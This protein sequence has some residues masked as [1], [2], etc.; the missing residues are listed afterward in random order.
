MTTSAFAV[1]LLR[2]VAGAADRAAAGVID[3]TPGFLRVFVFLEV[4]NEH[5][6]A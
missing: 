4:G 3:P 6:R 2:L 1:R 5:V